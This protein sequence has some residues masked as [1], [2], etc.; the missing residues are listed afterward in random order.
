MA[1][2]RTDVSE[3][4]SASIVRVTRNGKLGTTVAEISNRRTLRRN[5]L[6]RLLVTAD[7]PNSPILFTLSRKVKNSSETSVVTGGGRRNISEDDILHNQTNSV[8]LSP[9]ANYTD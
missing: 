7:V 5:S 3:E 1:L 4:R 9:H 2:V 8:A 6:L